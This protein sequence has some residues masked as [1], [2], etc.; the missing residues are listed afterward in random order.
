MTRPRQKRV[1][2]QQLAEKRQF[3]KIMDVLIK[4]TDAEKLRLWLQGDDMDMTRTYSNTIMSG[5][6]PL[7][8]IAAVQP[9]ACVVEMLVRCMAGLYKNVPL[10]VTDI[11]GRTP[12]HVAAIYG[13]T[14][15][16]Q[17]LSNGCSPE[18]LVT[19]PLIQDIWLRCP[20]HWA[21]SYSKE[22]SGSVDKIFSKIVCGKTKGATMVDAVRTLIEA[23][24]EATLIRD[25]DGKTSFDLA[26]AN[27]ADPRII[28]ILDSTSKLL[29]RA[30]E[31]KKKGFWDFQDDDASLSD[32]EEDF[33]PNG[34]PGEISVHT[35]PGSSYDW[36]SRYEY[37]RFEC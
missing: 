8:L 12:L 17:I 34:F 13:S 20:L 23:Y 32:T 1:P 29:H 31:G 4:E 28:A 26:L 33:F 35:R 9:T 19:A 25:R 6:T 22:N 21:C 18:S 3:D 27:K 37:E 16:I 15:A 10:D 2:F 11:M 5:E 36:E 14:D 30:R 7:H 24:P